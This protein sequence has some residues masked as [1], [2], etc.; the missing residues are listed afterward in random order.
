M[1]QTNSK[2]GK[3]LLINSLIIGIAYFPVAAGSPGPLD[4]NI[5]LGFNFIISLALV[6][7]ETTVTLHLKSEKYLKIFFLFHNQ[8]LQRVKIF[9]YFL[10]IQNLFPSFESFQI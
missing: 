5:P 8:L 2:K 10:K 4:K 1:T 9:S 6:L 3:F 7:Q